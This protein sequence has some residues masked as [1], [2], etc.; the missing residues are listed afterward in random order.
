VAR[1]LAG[2]YRRGP[3]LLAAPR[4]RGGCR[5]PRLRSRTPCRF[6]QPVDGVRAQRTGASP[7]QITPTSTRQ[8]HRRPSRTPRV[9]RPAVPSHDQRFGAFPGQIRPFP[10]RSPDHAART[11]FGGAACPSGQDP[12]CPHPA[13]RRRR[14]CARSIR[15]R[16]VL[17][18]GLISGEGGSRDAYPRP[19]TPPAEITSVL[20]T[21]GRCRRER[22]L[23][24]QRSMSCP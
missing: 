23:G 10:R 9:H 5:A 6:T 17:F 1:T 7:R 20:L 16:K 8:P 2:M 19:L 15:R 11:A 13:R 3:T 14:P 18:Q 21:T 22:S 24:N 4:P 12:A